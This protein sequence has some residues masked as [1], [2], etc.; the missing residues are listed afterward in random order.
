V[1]IP[2]TI[3]EMAIAVPGEFEVLAAALAAADLVDTL[4]GLGPFTVFAPTD[5]AFAALPPGV[6]DALL[7][8]TDALRQVLL[9]HVVG[10]RVLSGDLA[11]GPVTTLQGNSVSVS[12]EGGVFVNSSQVV[13]AD[14]QGLNGVIHVINEVLIPPSNILAQLRADGRF[15]TLLSV[16]ELTG[17]D[18]V[19]AGND[20]LTLFAPTDEAFAAVD[21]DV[22]ADLVASRDALTAV[23]LYHVVGGA[24]FAADLPDGDLVSVQGTALSVSPGS[25]TINGTSIVAADLE[26]SNGVIHV[27]GGVLLP[28]GGF[29]LAEENLRVNSRLVQGALRLV[30]LAPSGGEGSVLTSTQGVVQFR[31]S[32]LEGDWE[33]LVVDIAVVGGVR[34]AQLP[35]DDRKGFFRVAF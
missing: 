32:L 23:L 21:P 34:V 7:A 6:L 14:L 35:T 27:L 12:L 25:G 15:G 17:L 5:A 33:D 28:E 8:D 26:S 16:L 31:E 18:A 4:Q 20:A 22:L 10:A 1:L 11:A 13:T 9:Y 2:P 24:V 29:T 30:W 19:L 3:V